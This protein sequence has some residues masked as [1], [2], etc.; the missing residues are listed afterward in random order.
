MVFHKGVMAQN[1]MTQVVFHTW[2]LALEG[3]IALVFHTS[4]LALGAQYQWFITSGN[5]P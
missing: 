5:W 3:S 4:L 1:G 2:K